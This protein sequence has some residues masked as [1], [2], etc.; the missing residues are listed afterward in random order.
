V[1]Y[2]DTTVM[3]GNGFVKYSDTTVTAAIDIHMLRKY[4]IDGCHCETLF[5]VSREWD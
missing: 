1:K 5:P 2:S 3:A 4:F